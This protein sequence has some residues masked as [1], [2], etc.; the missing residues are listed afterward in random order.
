MYYYIVNPVAG[1][2]RTRS[3]Q[4]KLRVNLRAI[5]IDGEFARTTG[6]GD[7]TRLAKHAIEKGYTTIVAV[8]GDG[9]VNEVINGIGEANVAIGIMPLGHTNAVAG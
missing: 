1:N 3:L 7:A 9:T 5:G 4:D 8:G 6:P 2:S